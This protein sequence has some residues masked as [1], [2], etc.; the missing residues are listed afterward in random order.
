MHGSIF[1][2]CVSVVYGCS[3][4]EALGDLCQHA[5]APRG[6]AHQTQVL[7]DAVHPCQRGVPRCQLKRLLDDIIRVLVLTAMSRDRKHGGV[8]YQK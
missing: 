3:Y 8:G 6:I 5:T 1:C 4:R 7:A 2:S